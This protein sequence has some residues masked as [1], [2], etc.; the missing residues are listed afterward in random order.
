M[1]QRNRQKAKKKTMIN[2]KIAAKTET[3]SKVFIEEI[4]RLKSQNRN[5]KKQKPSQKHY[6]ST[7]VK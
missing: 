6:H 5:K 3:K 2:M 1:K 7:K 4:Y